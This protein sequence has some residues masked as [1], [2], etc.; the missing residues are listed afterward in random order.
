MYVC[1]YVYHTL[2]ASP[3]PLLQAPYIYY[4]YLILNT[5]THAGNLSVYTER[6]NR[7]V[8]SDRLTIIVSIPEDHNNNKLL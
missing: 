1:I 3:P 5:M 6:K 2:Q 4:Y 8:E 7:L